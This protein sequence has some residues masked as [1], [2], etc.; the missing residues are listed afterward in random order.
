MPLGRSATLPL[1]L[2]SMSWQC[3]CYDIAAARTLEHAVAG[4]PAAT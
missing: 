4:T 3:P 2:L 1:G